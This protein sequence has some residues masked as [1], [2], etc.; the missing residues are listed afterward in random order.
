MEGR[1]LERVTSGSHT[2]HRD[3][4]IGSCGSERAGRSE[5]NRGEGVMHVCLLT[6]VEVDDGGVPGHAGVKVRHQRGN[7]LR[8]R[9]HP[10]D[11]VTRVDEP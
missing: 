6:V 4:T 7:V 1:G 2:A 8:G 3:F 10:M 5:L 11:H 9:E